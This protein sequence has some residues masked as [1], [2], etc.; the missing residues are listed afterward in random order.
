[1]VVSND[2]CFSI[3]VVSFPENSEVVD[4]NISINLD[5]SGNSVDVEVHLD[6][7]F[8]N[9]SDG[10][11]FKEDNLDMSVVSPVCNSNFVVKLELEFEVYDHLG[12]SD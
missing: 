11:F 5:L 8:M 6:L 3:A 1:M 10:V 12:K 4:D 9:N 2:I 7:E